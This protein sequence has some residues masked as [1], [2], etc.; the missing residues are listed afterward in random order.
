MLLCR[1]LVFD[2]TSKGFVDGM[3]LMVI[4]VHLLMIRLIKIIE[5][6]TY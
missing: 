5:I 2:E 4:T 3:Y 6:L 1:G